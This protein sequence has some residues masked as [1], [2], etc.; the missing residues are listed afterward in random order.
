MAAMMQEISAGFVAS[1]VW[2][3]FSAFFPHKQ[4]VDRVI[5]DSCHDPGHQKDHWK[6]A[7]KFAGPEHAVVAGATGPSHARVGPGARVGRMN[8]IFSY[9]G[10]L[11]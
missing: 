7:R 1:R 5:N 6:M 8:V 3:F 9:G 11:K 2:L 4:H 10:F